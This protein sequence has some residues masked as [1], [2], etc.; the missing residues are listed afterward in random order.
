M[1]KSGNDLPE[2]DLGILSLCLDGFK[3]SAFLLLTLNLFLSKVLEFLCLL[4]DP[5][6]LSIKSLGGNKSRLLSSGLILVLVGVA[7][8]VS[9][10]FNS[11]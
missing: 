4:S 7:S 10:V 11:S 9:I 5:L 8:A 1:L 3:T 2:D 6:T